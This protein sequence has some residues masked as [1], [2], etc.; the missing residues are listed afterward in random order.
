MDRDEERALL[1]RSADLATAG[2][3]KATALLEE[4]LELEPLSVYAS[5]N[6]ACLY[7]LAGKTALSLHRLEGA[8]ELGFSELSFARQ[9]PD[10]K[11]LHD[12]P[13]FRH[14]VGLDDA[15]EEESSTD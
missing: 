11:S 12:N 15:A 10:L 1:T 8:I 9:D 5:Y 4:L 13:R 2:A 7:A 3:E 6:L 14:L